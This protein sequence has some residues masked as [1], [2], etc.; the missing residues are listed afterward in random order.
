MCFIVRI[1]SIIPQCGV[2]GV[3]YRR[4]T[5]IHLAAWPSPE[6]L[7]ISLELA[8]PKA[9]FDYLLFHKSIVCRLFYIL[10]CGCGPNRP[11]GP[12]VLIKDSAV[13]KG[14]RTVRN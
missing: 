8:N 1:V 13:Y 3:N 4:V 2:R 11:I 5:N 6:E 14:A 7:T 9:P 10:V 12:T